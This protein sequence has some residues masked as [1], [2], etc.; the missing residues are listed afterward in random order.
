M[1]S[2]PRPPPSLPR[3]RRQL[4]LR[5]PA[6]GLALPLHGSRAAPPSCSRAPLRRR[7]LQQQELR[8]GAAAR[9]AAGGASSGRGA[10]GR[11]PMPW[12]RHR[13]RPRRGELVVPLRVMTTRPAL[14]QRSV[15]RAAP[16]SGTS[17]TR[18]TSASWSGR[19]AATPTTTTPR[20][21]A[22]PPSRSAS[23][24]RQTSS[25]LQRRPMGG[26]LAPPQTAGLR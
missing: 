19:A 13:Q 18:P 4:R 10:P 26:K 20:S 2:G 7:P 23:R 21:G 16:S 17:R 14:L 8:R 3:R 15:R 6:A 24:S 5:R 22:S 12:T 11:R 9:R 25:S 1:P